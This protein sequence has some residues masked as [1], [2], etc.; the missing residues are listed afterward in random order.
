MIAVYIGADPRFG[1]RNRN[2][3]HLHGCPACAR[4]YNEFVHQMAGVR[5]DAVAEADAVF[6]PARLELQRQQIMQRLEHA[7]HPARVIPFPSPGP[8][9]LSMFTGVQVRRWIAAAAAA[10]LLIGLTVGRMTGFHGTLLSN[11]AG[12]VT[13]PVAQRVEPVMA[14]ATDGQPRSVA[15]PSL[16]DEEIL[17]RAEQVQVEMQL[18]ASLEALGAMTP[19]RDVAATLPPRGR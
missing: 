1:R 7:A 4:R 18:P 19:I 9:N 6:S 14:K 15:E 12:R 17:S 2:L 8:Q 5:E 13:A 10:G 11:D 3:D 16:N